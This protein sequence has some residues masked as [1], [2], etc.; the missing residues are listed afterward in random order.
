MSV[1]VATSET[2]DE[3]SSEL[4]V[5]AF[6]RPDDKIAVVIVAD[7]IDGRGTPPPNQ[8]VNLVIKTRLGTKV[9]SV[10]VTTRSISTILIN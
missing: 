6:L 7:A 1:T 3:E 9:L 2:K 10:D 8:K 5:A 4:K